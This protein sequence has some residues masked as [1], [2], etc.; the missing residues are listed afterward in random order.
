MGALHL[1]RGLNLCAHDLLT[2][3]AASHAASDALSD[4]DWVP[5]GA[6]E[7]RQPAEAPLNADQGDVGSEDGVGD[8]DDTVDD[9]PDNDTEDDLAD[10]LW[11]RDES[12]ARSGQSYQ[13]TKHVLS[14]LESRVRVCVCVCVACCEC[15]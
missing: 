4:D 6:A 5:P 8:A 1:G 12:S 15:I 2:L 3:V 10:D 7:Q 9:D 13:P 11:L 14:A